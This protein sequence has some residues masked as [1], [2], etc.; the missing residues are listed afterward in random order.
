[1]SEGNSTNGNGLTR[2]AAYYRMSDDDQ[3]NSPDR[4]RSQVR[5]YCRR[6]DYALVREYTD[7]GIA[8]DEFERRAGFQQLLADARAGLFDVIVADEWSR[9]SRQDPLDFL[10]TVVRPLRDA[11]VRLETVAEGPQSWDNLG[12]QILLV[13]RSGK[14]SDEAKVLSRRVLTGMAKFAAAGRVLAMAP[15]GYKTEYETVEEPGKPPKVKPVRFVPDPATAPVVS[16]IFD[17]YAAGGV[18]LDDLCHELTDRGAPPPG[19]NGGRQTAD[20]KARRRRWT[21]SAVRFILRNP[22]YTGAMS[23]NRRARGKYHAL[24]ADGVVTPKGKPAEAVNGKAAWVI[25]RGT[26]EALVSQATFDAVQGRLT[27]HAHGG[28][29]PNLGGYLFSGLCVCGDCG[30]SF[31]GG[32]RRG[33]RVYWCNAHDDAG[34]KVCQYNSVREDVLLARV[35]DVLQATLADPERQA[36]LLAEAKATAEAGRKPAALAGLRKRLAKLDA[37]ITRGNSNLILLPPERVPAAVETLKRLEA[38][39]DRLAAD[40]G[41]RERAA[42]VADLQETFRAVETWL[43]KLADLAGRA[44]QDGVRAALRDTLKAGLERVEVSFDHRKGP[45]GRT[46]HVPSHGVI[47]LSD[48]RGPAR[49]SAWGDRVNP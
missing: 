34:V 15:Y 31:S 21:R 3:K 45:G 25:A 24:P 14:A 7:E 6:K 41:D 8:G 19:R 5:P 26:H 40:L 29:G 49:R 46:Q 30:R 18:T 35:L 22:K 37:Q 27:D 4:Q 11:G 42:G 33:R 36:R 17:R 47:Y 2:A 23:W 16:W 12:G 43:G 9:L 13:V 38:D 32:T 20:G 39:R 28:R 10:A 1:M 44:D 48:D